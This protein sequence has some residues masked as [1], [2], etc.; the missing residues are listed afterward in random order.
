MTLR[1]DLILWTTDYWDISTMR[2]QIERAP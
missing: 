1:D 2:R